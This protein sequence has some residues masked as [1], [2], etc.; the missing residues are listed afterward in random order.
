M[1]ATPYRLP[2]GIIAASFHPQLDQGKPLTCRFEKPY[3]FTSMSSKHYS[4]LSLPV[5]VGALGFFVDIYDLLLFNIVRL[6]SFRDLGVAPE[7]MKDVGENVI[8][9]QMIGLVIG[10]IAWGIMGDKKGR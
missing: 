2:D 10:G 9:W 1:E 4:I 8:S 5:I 6:S 7:Y 3:C